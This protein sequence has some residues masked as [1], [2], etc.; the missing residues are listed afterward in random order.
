MA[1]DYFHAGHDADAHGLAEEAPKVQEPRDERRGVEPNA[2]RRGVE[3]RD[4]DRIANDD[5]GEQPFGVEQRGEHSESAHGEHR[6]EPT[7]GECCD[8]CKL[9]C[10]RNFWTELLRTVTKIAGVVLAALGLQSFGAED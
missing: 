3:P 5:D 10:K 4:G 1:K 9:T 6:G 7:H 2:E 8:E